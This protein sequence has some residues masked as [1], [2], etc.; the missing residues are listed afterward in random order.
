MK[1][2]AISNK[3]KSLNNLQ[4]DEIL[5]AAAIRG[6]NI[7]E[8]INKYGDR[9]IGFGTGRGVWY[10]F[11]EVTFDDSSLDYMRFNQ[12]YSQNNGSVKKS[13]RAGLIAKEMIRSA[14]DPN[15]ERIFS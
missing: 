9:T 3:N 11:R 15:F 6:W 4:Y 2:P 7:E 14:I 1:N 10:W 5:Q 8:D 12:R 13:F